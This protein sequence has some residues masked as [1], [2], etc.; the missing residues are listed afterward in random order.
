MSMSKIIP[1]GLKLTD[2][3]LHN[4]AHRAATR[5]FAPIGVGVRHELGKRL[6]LVVGFHLELGDA[7]D[8]FSLAAMKV[9]FHGNSLLLASGSP[10]ATDRSRRRRRRRRR[11]PQTANAFPSPP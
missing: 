4:G 11:C 5:P 3:S 10:P 8:P 6:R 9:I 1:A 2:F 7:R